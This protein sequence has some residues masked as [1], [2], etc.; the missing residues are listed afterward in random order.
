[1]SGGCFEEA[2]EAPLPRPGGQAQLSR[3]LVARHCREPKSVH[4]VLRVAGCI[5]P[6]TSCT[7]AEFALS[8][9]VRFGKRFCTRHAPL[10]VLRLQPLPN[11]E[12]DSG[13]YDLSKFLK[14]HPG[15]RHRV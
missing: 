3:R 5:V 14:L 6:C 1:M 15:G 2:E 4:P 9:Q 11:T 8:V 10:F 12:Q 7:A 13:V